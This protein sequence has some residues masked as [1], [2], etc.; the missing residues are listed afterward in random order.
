MFCLF[1][2]NTG[3]A[4]I[5]VG[6]LADISDDGSRI[7]ID[8][9]LEYPARKDVTYQIGDDAKWHICTVKECVLKNGAEGFAAF[10]SV[11]AN[12]AYGRP[13]RSFRVLLALD[14]E[15]V[16]ALEIQTVSRM[17]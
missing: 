5:R 2:A 3:Q 8:E 12:E 16:S 17:H 11:V 15:K 7:T 1:T 4:E 6:Q 9:A 14:G 10:K 13:Y